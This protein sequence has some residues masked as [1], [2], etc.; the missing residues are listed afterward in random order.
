MISAS[1]VLC[2]STFLIFWNN[3]WVPITSILLSLVFIT[4]LDTFTIYAYKTK[5]KI[6]VHVIRKPAIEN[7]LC[8]S[9]LRKY[10][11][12]KYQTSQENH[13]ATFLMI[14]Y[15]IT[16]DQL[17]KITTMVSG[18]PLVIAY[19]TCQGYISHNQSLIP[20]NY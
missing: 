19:D 9:L 17:E 18:L 5:R 3:C 4:I 8:K 10:I 12:S 15:C 1:V 14:F 13:C 11:V 2:P 7:V 16:S 6:Q 20:D